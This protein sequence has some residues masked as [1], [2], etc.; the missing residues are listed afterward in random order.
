MPYNSNLKAAIVESGYR[1]G[2]LA[3]KLGL[4]ESMIS[5]FITG[6]R[7][8]TKEQRKA[9]AKI[10]KTSQREIFGNAKSA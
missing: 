6:R 10:L 4:H 7:E 1:Q 8:P 2:W 9:L 5:H 3:N